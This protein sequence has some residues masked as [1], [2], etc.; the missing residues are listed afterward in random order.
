MDVWF[1]LDPV[2][3]SLSMREALRQLLNE[4]PAS[5]L[6]LAPSAVASVFTPVD[7]VDTGP[8]IVVQANLPG[9]KADDISVTF[10]DNTLTIKADVKPS[11]EFKSATYL[12]RERRATTYSR[13]I[14]FTVPLDVEHADAKVEDGVLTLRL[15]KSE[16]VR[17]KTVKI[18][19]PT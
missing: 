11:G 6:D 16:K 17:P 10:L 2:S 12:R 8:E 15:P 9:I 4:R 18:M 3:E 19:T 5:P 7:V 1:G 13:S 14:H